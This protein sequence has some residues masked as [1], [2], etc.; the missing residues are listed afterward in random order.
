MDRIGNTFNNFL[1]LFGKPIPL[2]TDNCSKLLKTKFYMIENSKYLGILSTLTL[3][4][5]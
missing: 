3:H 5:G 2:I 4:H 1:S